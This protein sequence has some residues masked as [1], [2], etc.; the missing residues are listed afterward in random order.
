MTCGHI[1]RPPSS[2]P[3]YCNAHQHAP[4]S[5][6]LNH[7]LIY[8]V[9]WQANIKYNHLVQSHVNWVKEINL[10]YSILISQ[11]R[12]CTLYLCSFENNALH[13]VKREVN[14]STKMRRW[15]SVY[16]PGEGNL[17]CSNTTNLSNTITPCL[18]PPPQ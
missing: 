15:R 16:S 9:N 11:C 17:Q 7:Y 3:A 2:H 1:R 6:T 10:F 18:P 8:N 13:T 14:L 5:P 4:R 12:V